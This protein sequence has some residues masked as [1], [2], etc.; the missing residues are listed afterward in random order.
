M[1]SCQ[2]LTETE[3]GKVTSLPEATALTGRLCDNLS[4]GVSCV[5]SCELDG[6]RNVG[7]CLPDPR[8]LSQSWVESVSVLFC[9]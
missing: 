1:L 7:S 6:P 9:A 5:L 8:L 3:A 2:Y 4:L